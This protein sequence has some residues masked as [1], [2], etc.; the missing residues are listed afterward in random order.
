MRKALGISFVLH[1]LFFVW[2][3]LAPT[4]NESFESLDSALQTRTL[5]PEEF[6]KEFPEEAK[7]LK[8]IVREAVQKLKTKQ[9]VQSDDKLKSKEAPNPLQESYLARHNQRFDHNTRAARVGEFKN[10]LK[11]GLKDA[12]D[13]FKIDAHQNPTLKAKNDTQ[14]T[15]KGSTHSFV[16]KPVSNRSPASMPAADPL[17]E[18]SSAA[19]GD[20]LSATDDYLPHVAIAANTL[21]NTREYKYASFYERIR[22]K[23]NHQ[24]QRLVRAEMESLYLQGVPSI[25]GERTTKLRIALDPQGHVTKIEKY[26]SAGYQELDRAAVSAFKVAGPFSNPPQELL[27]GTDQKI[28]SI[29]WHF[30]VVGGPTGMR[31]R[32][33]RHPAGM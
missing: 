8:K 1:A 9:I 7:E 23:L 22:E 32:I 24:W 3:S 31:V 4:S 6:A 28:V 11:E 13:L 19:Q 10:V 20:G 29:D 16:Q 14:P 27:E 26:G 17:N 12:R 5:S 18:A 21:L 15:A 33:R 2:I 25:E 30:V